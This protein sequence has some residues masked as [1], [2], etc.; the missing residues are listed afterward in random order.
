MR[1]RIPPPEYI[2]ESIVGA[3]YTLLGGMALV[4]G[5]VPA[6][7][8]AY[9]PQVSGTLTLRYALPLVPPATEALVP[10][11]MVAERGGAL[12]GREAWDFI[13]AQFLVH[14]RADVIGVKGNGTL[15]QVFLRELDFGLPI[16]VFVYTAPDSMVAAA[17]PTVLIVGADAPPLP[18]MLSKYL[19]RVDDIATL[20]PPDARD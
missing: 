13:Q 19:P 12:T 3:V 14:P 20:L 8:T 15:A 9:S 5:T 4:V 10:G 1:S 17:H 2:S 6:A 16:A 7:L 18:E 11:L